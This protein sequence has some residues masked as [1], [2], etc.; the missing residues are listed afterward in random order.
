MAV[1]VPKIGTRSRFFVMPTQETGPKPHRA[2]AFQMHVQ[3][4]H[5]AVPVSKQVKSAASPACD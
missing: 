2:L 5:A 1:M 3:L 4:H